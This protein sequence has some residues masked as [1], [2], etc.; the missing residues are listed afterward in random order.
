[1]YFFFQSHLIYRLVKIRVHDY[2]LTIFA[3]C[4]LL[5]GGGEWVFLPKKIDKIPKLFL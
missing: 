3:D 4:A 2:L 5:F 1:V